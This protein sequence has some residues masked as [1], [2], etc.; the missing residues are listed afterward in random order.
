MAIWIEAAT[1]TATSAPRMPSSVA[2]NSTDT[3]T[4]N[5]LICT[6]RFWIWGWIRLFST[7]W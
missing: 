3:I 1:G 7:C 4:R 6:A 2:P 5:G